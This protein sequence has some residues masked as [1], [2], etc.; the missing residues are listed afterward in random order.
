MAALAPID[1]GLVLLLFSVSGHLAEAGQLPLA[2]LAD[3]RL[4]ALVVTAALLLPGRPILVQGWRSAWA[5]APGMDTLVGLGMGSA[6]L[7]SL[8]ALLWP[9]VGWQCFFNEPVMLL[10]FVLMGRF[11]EERARF[12]TGR[13]LQELARLQPDEALLVLGDGVEPVRVGALRPGD[14][15]RLLPGDR[16]P[17]DSRVLDGQSTLDVSSLTGEPLPLLAAAGQE[18]S[19]G[20]LNLQSS[21]ELEVLRPGRESAV[22]RIIALVEGAQ[23]RKAPIQTLTDRVAGRFSV[24]VMLLAAVTFLFWWLI[25]AQLG[26]TSSVQRHGCTCTAAIAAWA[27]P[28][29]PLRLGTAAEH[30][31]LGGCL[32]LRLGIGDT[33]GDHGRQRPGSL[34]VLF[35]GGDVIEAASRLRLF[36]DK[37]GTLT[38][39]RP[40]CGQWIRGPAKPC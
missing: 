37:T 23:A 36:F 21:L 13:A 1:G 15:L 31:R 39:G 28:L 30:R 32:P 27:L 6:Y 24:V 16:V 11:L 38:V 19:A 40:T 8:V 33:H 20:A 9:A 10:G 18:L 14:R 29:K 22:A 12:R 3:I 7:A 25:G 2:P 34:R 17:V 4:H 26:P 5:G 35:R